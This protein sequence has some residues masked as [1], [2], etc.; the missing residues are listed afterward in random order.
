MVKTKF[1][2]ALKILV[3]REKIVELSVGNMQ[4]LI[5]FVLLSETVYIPLIGDIYY[6][7]IFSVLASDC[8]ANNTILKVE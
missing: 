1:Y 3:A 2:D 7:V 6:Q 8:R 4:C 5:L